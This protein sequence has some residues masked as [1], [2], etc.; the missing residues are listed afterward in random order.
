MTFLN[1][2]TNSL[3]GFYQPETFAKVLSLALASGRHLVVYGPAGHGKSEMTQE[4]LKG[5]DPFVLSFGEGMTEDKIYGGIDF[6][7]MNRADS[8][9]LQFNAQHSFLAHSIAV[10]EE[11]FDAPSNVLLS[12]K[13]TL[14]AKALRA[15]HQ[16]VASKVKTIVALT[17]KSPSE[18]SELGPSV[19]ALTERFPLQYEMRWANYDSN[20][21]RQMLAA[22]KS[23]SESG[24]VES[25]L[26][27]VRENCG[28]VGIGEDMMDAYATVLGTAADSGRP[29]SPRIAR[30]GLDVIMASA[31]IRGRSYVEVEDLAEVAYLGIDVG[32]YVDTI[33]RRKRTREAREAISGLEE[34]LTA[35]KGALASA[36]T[37]IPALQVGKAAKEIANRAKALAVTD[38]LVR[39]RENIEA[40]ANVVAKA[41]VELATSLTR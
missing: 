33:E 40:G 1:K 20:A 5:L 22:K 23:W 16:Q 9:V 13:D 8:P 27:E 38:D 29:A 15:G 37:P 34:Q 36:S 24:I 17:N 28:R 18:M 6:A 31:A 7:A 19:Q 32:D 2:V 10:F 30:A 3:S 35:L 12:L 11:L 21:Y 25:D 4:A 39:A 41:A 14:A 26:D